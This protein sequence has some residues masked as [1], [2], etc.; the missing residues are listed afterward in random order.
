MSIPMN[1]VCLQCYLRKHLQTAQ[2]LGDDAT[3]TAFAR[4]VHRMAQ[5]GCSGCRTVFD[6]APA[7]LSLLDRSEIIAHLL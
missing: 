1:A 3:A 6:V 4:A 5:R 2:A 7:D